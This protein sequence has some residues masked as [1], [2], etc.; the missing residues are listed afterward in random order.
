MR[1]GH[2]VGA[3][4]LGVLGPGVS[5]VLAGDTP[6]QMPAAADQTVDFVRDI[7]PL[8][9]SSCIQCHAKGKTKGGLSLETRAS[10][11]KGGDS[12]PAAVV[13][14]S[15]DSYIVKMVAGVDPDEQMPKKG[16]KWSPH[17][18]GLLRAWID[19]GAAWDSKIA[20]TR[21]EPANLKV[22]VVEVAESAKSHPLDALLEQYLESKGVTTPATISDAMF[23]RR[24]C[25][26]VTGALP[27]ADQLSA[28]LLDP[29]SD[30]RAKLV[31][32]LLADRR[33]YA[34]NWLSFWNDLLRNDYHGA[35]FIDGGRRQITGWLYN[36][37]IENKPYD[38]M[39]SQLVSPTKACEGFARGIIWR[40]TVNASMLPPMQAAQNTSQVFLGVN[41]KC[42]SCHDS[43]VSDYTLA[44]AY[45][46]AAVFSDGPLELIRC[47]QPQG[48]MSSPQFLFPKIGTIQGAT[49][50]VD[51]MKQLAAVL[52]SPTDGRFART[53]VNRLW[54]KLIGHGLVEPLD[55]MDKPAWDP[56]I[57]DWLAQDLVDHHFDLKHT[58]ETI[59][60]SRAY[61]L[62]SVDAPAPGAY[63][64][65]GPQVRRLTAEQFYDAITDMAGDSARFPD[66]LDIDFAKDGLAVVRATP[67]WMWTDEA[68]E[69]GQAR[70]DTEAAFDVKKVEEKKPDEKKPA[71]AK[72]GAAKTDTKKADDMKPDSK[73]ADAKAADTKVAEAKAAEAKK[74][75]D[76]EAADKKDAAAADPVEI[77]PRHR[78]VFR[79]EFALTSVPREAYAAVAASQGFSL[80]VNGRGAPGIRSDGER[81]G[82]ITTFNVQP[83]L[84]VGQNVIV[85]EVTSHTSKSL[86]DAE[87]KEFP[88]SKN[89]LNAISGVGCYVRLID[90]DGNFS[91]LVSDDTWHAMRAPPG[92]WR[93][94]GYDD[95]EWRPVT[96]L[97]DG[98]TPIDE[99]PALPPIT[100]QDFAN[101]PIDVGPTFQSAIGTI[102]QP[103][104]IR[105]SMLGADT[106][107]SALDRPTREQVMTS[108]I[109]APTTLQA[110]ELT[111]GKTL[112]ERLKRAAAKAHDAAAADPQAWVLHVYLHLLG[113]PPSDREVKLALDVIGTPVKEEG[114][115][116][117]LWAVTM[118]PEFDYVY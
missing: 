76:K 7:K 40:G 8:F 31:H 68:V 51:R 86:N 56:D 96:V 5:V 17:E 103:G 74:A 24:A 87:A 44:D 104:H 55:E 23:V 16:K 105:A 60:T 113:R 102:S 27:T 111:H 69:D 39:V 38:Q 107:M 26:D 19:Q 98:L 34:D 73:P 2:V 93:D 54:A 21:P 4:L 75:A 3:I 99:G 64:F 30:K 108:R 110:L 14:H 9:E 25:L 94:A 78:V 70:A 6:V 67:G 83:N 41:L 45:G 116:D 35:G 101:E 50:K 57:L 115:A 92:K 66:T 49:D 85:L 32:Q 37:L 15:A 59:M 61:Q 11:F 82:R 46:M 62:A 48:T 117:F 52:T 58:I 33:G 88:Q 106:L 89:H 112:D 79:K 22:R 71:D 90:A 97:A 72:L 43:F 47:D 95:S 65:L 42:A 18:V 81:N 28:F 109:T 84:Q 36:A 80:I 77:I 53:I 91:E 12:G 1:I 10:L 29:S 114:M 13:G 63:T 20:F 100:R 118:L